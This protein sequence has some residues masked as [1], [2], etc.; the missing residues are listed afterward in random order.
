MLMTHVLFAAF[1]SCQITR[2]IAAVDHLIIRCKRLAQMLLFRCQHVGGNR[3]NVVPPRPRIMEG[4]GT[5]SPQSSLCMVK[6]AE[7]F[8]KPALLKDDEKLTVPFTELAGEGVHYLGQTDDGIL[9][10]S[11]YRLFLQKNSTGAEVSVPLG[12]IESTQVRDLFH[13]I[14]NCKDAS[15]VK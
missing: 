11:N 13:L 9:A 4:S 14:V 6:P 3:V 8:P 1:R 5:G 15:T 7:L 10:L 12:L 2:D